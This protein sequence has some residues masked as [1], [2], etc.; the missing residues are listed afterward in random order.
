MFGKNK[1]IA[2]LEKRIYIP[3][4]RNLMNAVADEMQLTKS[5][6]AEFVRDGNFLCAC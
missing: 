3:D 5:D 4:G 6:I 1:K 2:E